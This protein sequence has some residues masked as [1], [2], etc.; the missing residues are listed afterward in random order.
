M[1]YHGENDLQ[2]A[3]NVSHGIVADTI[4]DILQQSFQNMTKACEKWAFDL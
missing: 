3:Q 2:T 4:E 1:V